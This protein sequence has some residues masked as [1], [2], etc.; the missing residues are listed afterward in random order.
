VINEHGVYVEGN[1]I[2]LRTSD[3]DEYV[4]ISE[5]GVSAS[6]ITA[7]NVAAKYDKWE[8]MV[9]SHDESDQHYT[10]VFRSLQ[11]VFDHLN[12]R[13]VDKPVVIGLAFSDNEYGDVSLDGVV[14]LKDLTIRASAGFTPTIVGTLTIAGCSGSVFVTDVN[15]KPNNGRNGITARGET[16]V[17]VYRCVFTGNGNGYGI[18]KNRGGSLYVINCE[19]YNFLRSVVSRASAHTTI[20]QCKGN[21]KINA[22]RGG[23]IYTCGYMPDSS[24]TF[25][26]EESWGGKVY[27]DNTYV[28]QGSGGGSSVPVLTTATYTATSTASYKGSGSKY[29][30]DVAQGWY[31]IIGRIR[32]CMWFDNTSIRNAMRGKTVL[33]AT[34]KLAMRRNVGRG[35]GVTVELSGTYSNSGASSAAVTKTYGTL[36][37]ANPGETVSFALPI[38]AV[39]DLVNGTINGLMLYS[40]DT[41]AYKERDY[42]KNY[43]VFDGA[44]DSTPP[45]LTVIYQ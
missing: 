30:N 32:G 11:E 4:H 24:T 22:D 3:G 2:D 39:T 14:L 8:Y 6:S 41:G 34:I 26:P 25:A 21:C 5:A 1:E 31:D 12:G 40:S 36:G 18:I 43:A 28:D 19:F 13:V 29:R 17:E 38:A 37:T 44:A 9:V 45:Q 20:I 16:Y 35:V 27:T 10:N 23:V 33:S 15:F 7:P 42:S